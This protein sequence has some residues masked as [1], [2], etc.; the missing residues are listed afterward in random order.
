MASTGDDD[1]PRS[2]AGRRY[3]PTGTPIGPEYQVNSYTTGDQRHASVAASD[4]GEFV[5][6][7]ESD[8]SDGTD[9]SDASVQSSGVS[10]LSLILLGRLRLRGRERLEQLRAAAAVEP[11][12]ASTARA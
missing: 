6:V 2:V 4:G 5:V 7:W 9:S 1:A 12:V 11:A 10:S 3:R 8:G